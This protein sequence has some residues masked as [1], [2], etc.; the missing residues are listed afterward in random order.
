[1][2]RLR[3]LQAALVVTPFALGGGQ[4]ESTVPAPMVVRY[5]SLQGEVD[6]AALN[7][8]LRESSTPEAELRLAWGPVSA[9][10][11]P[12]EAFVAL[13]A[14][15]SAEARDLARLL[16]KACKGVEE[17]VWTSFT[18]GA[19]ELPSILGQPGRDCVIGMASEMRWFHLEGGRKLFFHLEGKL[20]AEEIAAR[21]HTLFQPFGSGEVGVLAEETIR[22]ALVEPVDAAHGKKALEAIRKL[23][24][25]RRAEIEGGEVVLRVELASLRS[26]GP[27]KVADDEEKPEKADAA[28][29]LPSFDVQPVLAILA[30]EGLR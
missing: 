11:R 23:S 16:K 26:S 13:E 21:F 29:P 9:P 3:W 8:A 20:D 17:L 28:F 5:F 18:G 12:K 19:T 10:P 2:A 6:R 15:A 24:G 14:P 30:K 7:R 25:V 22:E 27:A 4:E 1:M